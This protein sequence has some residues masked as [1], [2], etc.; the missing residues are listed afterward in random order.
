[1]RKSFFAYLY[2]KAQIRLV[3]TQVDQSL[4][5]FATL[6]E[7]LPALIQKAPKILNK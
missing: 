6:I 3:I 2:Q 4:C 7:S 1:M 5:F